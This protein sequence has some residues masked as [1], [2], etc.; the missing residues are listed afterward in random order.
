[1]I[2]YYL[3][4]ADFTVFSNAVSAYALVVNKMAPEVG[5]FLLALFAAL[6]TFSSAF[7][8]L[9]QAEKEFQGI[10]HGFLSLWEMVVGLFNPQHYARLHKEPLV[11]WG[12]F[13]FLIF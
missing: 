13:V 8:C 5:L 1:M 6:L 9:D 12:C 2:L 10:Q 4:L 11:L 3:L 7:S